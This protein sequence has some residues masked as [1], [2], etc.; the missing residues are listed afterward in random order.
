MV[1]TISSGRFEDT[2]KMFQKPESVDFH[3]TEWN[4]T[5]HIEIAEK[6]L[7][8][9]DPKTYSSNVRKMAALA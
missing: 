5:N 6:I 7:K 3:V 1:D 4:E 9:F 2:N 8:M